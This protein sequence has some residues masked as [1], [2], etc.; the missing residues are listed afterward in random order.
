MARP[1]HTGL[2][3]LTPVLAAASNPTAFS[4]VLVPVPV[5]VPELRL[6]GASARRIEAGTGTGTF[7]GRL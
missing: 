5:N 2:A 4:P 1:L 7:A 6:P 3:A